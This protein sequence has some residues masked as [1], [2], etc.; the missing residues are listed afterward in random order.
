MLL[1]RKCFLSGEICKTNFQ[2]SV[3]KTSVSLLAYVKMAISHLF[4][5]WY[6]SR[7]VSYEKFWLCLQVLLGPILQISYGQN[8]V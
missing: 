1:L 6:G 2:I 8:F 4:L 5:N 3:C 7:N